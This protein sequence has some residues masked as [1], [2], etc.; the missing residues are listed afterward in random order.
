ML[1]LISLSLL[2]LC[3]TCIWN[4]V[5]EKSESPL[6]KT[7][8]ASEGSWSEAQRPSGSPLLTQ[9]LSSLSVRRLVERCSEGLGMPELFFEAGWEEQW[10]LGLVVFS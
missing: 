2:E 8:F 7:M 9:L 5:L 3:R 1:F 6:A 4:S 10:Q